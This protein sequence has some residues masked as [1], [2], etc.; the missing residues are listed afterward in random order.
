MTIGGRFPRRVN[1]KSSFPFL[2]GGDNPLIHK[3]FFVKKK[4]SDSIGFFDL[5][6]DEI[7]RI[8]FMKRDRD[9]VFISFPKSDEHAYLFGSDFRR[10]KDDSLSVQRKEGRI[11][12]GAFLFYPVIFDF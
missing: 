5:D 12:I 6:Y 10:S 11:I 3:N 2:N 1:S 8:T 7:D 9:S 4:V